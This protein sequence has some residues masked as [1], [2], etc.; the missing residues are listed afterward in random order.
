MR[1]GSGRHAGQAGP[2][3]RHL[4]VPGGHRSLPRVEERRRARQL[5][6]HRV[7]LGVR[8]RP[9][10]HGRHSRAAV[11]R[12]EHS[13]SR[14]PFPGRLGRRPPELPHARG[15]VLRRHHRHRRAGQHRQALRHRA[16][17]L[18]L[19]RRWLSGRRGRRGGRPAGRAPG[20]HALQEP[21]RRRRALPERRGRGRPLEQRH[22]R[23]LPP[24]LQ[25]ESRQRVPRRLPGV[26]R[27]RHGLES[28]HHRVA[29]QQLQTGVR[30]AATSTGSR[31]TRRTWGSRWTS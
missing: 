29:Q 16:H 6:L 17:R 23:K 15:D 10:Q 30:H 26:E 11:A 9:R 18:L 24:G 8:D 2:D 4:H 22:R 27:G 31:P 3:R 7:R 25:L 12:F 20:R 13:A 14:R 5:A 1:A 19:R 28:G 21:V